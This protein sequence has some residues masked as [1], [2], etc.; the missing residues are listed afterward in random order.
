MKKLNRKGFTLIEL[1][2]VIVIMAIILVVT[3]PNI[4]SSIND[5]RVSS[6]WNLAKSAAETYDKAFAQDLISTNKILG[7][8]PDKLTTKWQCLDDVVAD[9]AAEGETGITLMSVLELS[10]NDIVT[11]GTEPLE[12]LKDMT[13]NDTYC[14]AIRLTSTGSAEVLLVAKTTGK[15][16]VA[17]KVTYAV[18][19]ADVGS[20]NDVSAAG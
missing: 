13:K 8:I 9:P 16:Y 6:I 20:Q 11:D 17:Q 1:L 14:S 7:N 3:V 4:I 18:S 15:F 12:K 5:A 10:T 19:S 2:A